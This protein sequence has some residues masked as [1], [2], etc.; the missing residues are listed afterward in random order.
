MS[1]FMQ[2]LPHF[3]FTYA[4]S[5]N[6][7]HTHA[8][9]CYLKKMVTYISFVCI[10]GNLRNNSIFEQIRK[11]SRRGQT[12]TTHMHVLVHT[13][14]NTY[15][16]HLRANTAVPWHWACVLY[17]NQPFPMWTGAW[18]QTHSTSYQW[19]FLRFVNWKN[20]SACMVLSLWVSVPTQL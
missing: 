2:V 6:P 16:K 8:S 18:P 17:S 19:L 15:T 12:D 1:I 10:E 13:H 11:K 4:F 20:L 3:N 9:L 5:T 14:T 7:R